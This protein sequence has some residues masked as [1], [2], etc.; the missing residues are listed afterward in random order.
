[1]VSGCA[2]PQPVKIA[3]PPVA[4]PA[5]P[6]STVATHP[7][8]GEEGGFARLGNIPAGHTPIRIGVLL[9]FGNGS[10]ATR[11][12]ANSL[13]KAAELALF[14]SKNRD[15]MLISADEG[16][17]RETAAS[18]ARN[19]LA[20]GAEVIIGPLF[21]QSVSAVAPI[22]RDHGVPLIS[23]STDIS[24]AGDGVYL[25][26][27]QPGNEVRRVV[28]YAATQG[29]S[30]FAALIPAT[31][32]GERVEAAF[33]SSVK[34]AGAQIADVE[35]FT[36]AAGD[37]VTPA[38]QVAKAKPDSILIAQGGSLLSDIAPTLSTSGAG[39]H[40]VQYLGTGLWDDPAI[41]REPN[42]AGG[43]FAAPDPEAERA[44]EARYHA[45][46]GTNPAQLAAL[47][48]DAVSLVAL[49][50]SGPAYHRFTPQTLTDPN[51]FSGADGI[52]RFNSDGTCERGLAILG[53]DPDEGF[54]LISPAPTTFQGTPS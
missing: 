40:Q 18:G 45:T 1:M 53:V 2:E 33:R 24:V 12:L 30:N 48:Y 52:F 35:K 50:A 13:M 51:G 34:A 29:H 5:P 37:I 22:T 23:F 44:F 43:W 15:L 49:L 3:K 28:K 9:P 17:G 16:Y 47:G 31:V 4:V 42:L 41:S 6:P 46:F 7:L 38:Q 19:L 26:S 36:P 8:T 11:A 14:E 20:Q 32:Y 54:K 21:A 39:S 27:F 10:P 25:L